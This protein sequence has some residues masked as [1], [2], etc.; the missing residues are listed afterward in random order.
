LRVN[1]PDARPLCGHV[2]IDLQQVGTEAGP[3]VVRNQETL[4]VH[5]MVDWENERLMP[6]RSS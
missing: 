5:L 6:L 4:S 1:A 2:R 3:A